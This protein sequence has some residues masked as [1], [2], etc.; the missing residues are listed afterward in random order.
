MK[1]AGIFESGKTSSH[2]CVNYG[3][4]ETLAWI[5]MTYL[6]EGNTAESAADV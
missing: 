2:G 5:G 3:Y 6:Q 4:D 1:A